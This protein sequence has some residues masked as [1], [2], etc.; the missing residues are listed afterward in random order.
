LI[1]EGAGAFTFTTEIWRGVGATEVGEGVFE[2]RRARRTRR[3]EETRG[4]ERGEES[5]RG[6]GN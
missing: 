5:R 2:P 6:E 4:E 1:Q 3:G